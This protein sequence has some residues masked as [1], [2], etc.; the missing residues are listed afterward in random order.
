[1]RVG[2]ALVVVVAGLWLMHAIARYTGSGRAAFF[3]GLVMALSPLQVAWPRLALTETLALATTMWVMTELVLSMAEQ[4][5]RIWTTAIAL[6]A[7]VFV[8]YDG[9]LLCLPVV[10]CA[11]AIH[12]P[13]QA[14]LRGG[15]IALI[16]ALPALAWAARSA[17]AG[18]GYYPPGWSYSVGSTANSG[19]V[20]WARTWST[21][22]YDFQK[23]DYTV[24]GRRY[25]DIRIDDRAFDSNEE[26]VRVDGLLSELASFDSKPFPRH[27][28]AAFAALAAER[29]DRNPLRHWVWN[30]L[31]RAANMWFTPFSSFGWPLEVPDALRDAVRAADFSG[32][33][34]AIAQHP[35]I[36]AGKAVVAGYRFALVIGFIGACAYAIAWRERYLLGLIAIAA[37]IV[38]ARTVFFS[39][40]A[41]MEA[42]YMMEAVPGI[43]FVAVLALWE[44]W[45]RR[46]R[47]RQAAPARSFRARRWHGMSRQW[48]V[49]GPARAW[50]PVGRARS[51]P[52]SGRSESGVVF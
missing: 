14:L 42:R 4:R 39:V 36:A 46:F 33:A 25:S 29:R 32:V 47:P 27:V 40:T 37:I 18:L 21:H 50:V 48:P 34:A 3:V 10:F 1:M 22:E 8:R 44:T 38:A 35:W 19:F 43:E 49:S 28:N 31:R 52:S 9:A 16:L 20:A 5:L 41:L 26:R 17:D 11:F 24:S 23:W 12:R 13:K 2:Q 45:R 6:A 51:P 7:A 15:A 30:P